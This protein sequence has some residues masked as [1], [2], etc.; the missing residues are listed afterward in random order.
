MKDFGR[1]TTVS[2]YGHLPSAPVVVAHG[3]GTSRVHSVQAGAVSLTI[4]GDSLITS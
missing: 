1:R 3:E 4:R 2:R